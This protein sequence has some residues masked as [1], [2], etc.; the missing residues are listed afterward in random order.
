MVVFYNILEM[1]MRGRDAFLAL[2]CRGFF[3]FFYDEFVFSA[4]FE[5]SIHGLFGWIVEEVGLVIV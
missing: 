5:G 4:W 1:R 3:P 2:F